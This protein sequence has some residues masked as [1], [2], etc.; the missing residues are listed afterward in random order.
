VEINYEEQRLRGRYEICK[1][2]IMR[3]DA[4]KKEGREYTAGEALS[5]LI[6]EVEASRDYK[7]IY[8]RMKAAEINQCE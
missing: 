3:D 8:E 6:Q 1:I 7:I 4:R 5:G 2:R